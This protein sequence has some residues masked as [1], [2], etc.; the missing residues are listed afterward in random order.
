MLTQMHIIPA[1]RHFT[2]KYSKH[3]VQ[4]KRKNNFEAAVVL[5]EEEPL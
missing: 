5:E 4:I 1:C 2:W 3:I